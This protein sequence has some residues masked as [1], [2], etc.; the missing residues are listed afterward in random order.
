MTVAEWIAC[1]ETFLPQRAASTVKREAQ[2]LGPFVRAHGDELVC[3]V[4]RAMAQRWAVAHPAQIKCLRRCW[5]VAIAAGETAENPF[6]TVVLPP[7]RKT[8]KYR[9]PTKEELDLAVTNCHVAGG[10]CAKTFSKVVQVMAYTGARPGGICVL[11]PEDVNFD[12]HRIQLLEKGNKTRIVVLPPVAEIALR[13]AMA[14]NPWGRTV[15]RS[16][17]RKPLTVDQIGRCWREVRGDYPYPVRALRHYAAT[18]L[19]GLGADDLD[20]A[21]QLGHTDDQGRP[22]PEHVQRTYRHFDNAGALNRLERLVYA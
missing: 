7:K 5:R 8:P 4:D 20:I 2:I 16:P 1:W 12:I 21:V 14:D 11:E 17:F 6:E 10:W 3:D 13:G 22:Y 15:F 19:H 18:W 9:P